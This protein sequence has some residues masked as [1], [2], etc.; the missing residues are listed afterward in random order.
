MST[1]FSVDSFISGKATEEWPWGIR[2][3]Y[4]RECFVTLVDVVV[5]Y[6][7]VRY[8]LPSAPDQFRGTVPQ[9]LAF[10][11]AEGV[12]YPETRAFPSQILPE[13]PEILEQFEN[14]SAWAARPAHA[15]RLLKWLG[16]QGQNGRMY[17]SIPNYIRAFWSAHSEAV[18]KLAV[19]IAQANRLA[20]Q[21]AQDRSTSDFRDG[22]LYAFSAMFR[23][24][25]YRVA[26]CPF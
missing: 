7:E 24:L 19:G 23:G 16:L 5:N 8:P 18:E 15:P 10:L 14:F 2:D 20:R 11:N 3:P 22:L 26:P 13:A 1:G 4:G 6:P 21:A 12:V 25:E 17:Y 9:S